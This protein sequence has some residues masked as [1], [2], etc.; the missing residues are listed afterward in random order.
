MAVLPTTAISTASTFFSEATDL[1]F[2]NRP[3]LAWLDHG[4]RIVFDVRDV[5]VSYGGTAAISGVGVS[6][7][8]PHQVMSA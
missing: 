7:V 5:A 8:K 2:R 4:G 6:P 1:T 3:M